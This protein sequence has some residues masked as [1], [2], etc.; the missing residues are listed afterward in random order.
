MHANSIINEATK[1]SGQKTIISNIISEIDFWNLETDP[2]LGKKID[3]NRFAQNLFNK[4]KTLIEK[5]SDKTYALGLDLND[6][7]K[8]GWYESSNY[9]DL[10]NL[11]YEIRTKNGE[12]IYENGGLNIKEMFETILK[13]EVSSLAILAA[14]VLNIGW[15]IYN[16]NI[17]S[18]EYKNLVK[19]DEE[20]ETIKER[21]NS[22]KRLLEKLPDRIIDAIN[23]IKGIIDYIK[24]DYT[25][26]KKHING[27][28]QKKEEA[29]SIKTQSMIG[30][31]V[32]LVL[33]LF[34]LGG[35]IISIGQNLFTATVNGIS[36]AGNA[37]ALNKHYTNYELSKEVI[38]ELNEKIKRANKFG[39]EMNN[40]IN[41][42][43][44]EL[45]SKENEI[46]KFCDFEIIENYY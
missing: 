10:I 21:F 11:D 17:I 35:S 28:E 2:I 41:K 18:E 45:K 22:H 23:Y 1:I 30:M 15:S 4:F 24:D 42:L 33:G 20:F 31:G 32:S 38:R 7:S 5:D 40:F 12:I 16:F 46:P 26:L 43:I 27:V 19:I 13:D 8:S 39:N 36:T 44:D 25:L 9:G 29:E 37:Y 3:R 14:S 6:F 34:S